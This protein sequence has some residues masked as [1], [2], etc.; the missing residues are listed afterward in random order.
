MCCVTVR[1][2]EQNTNFT[3]LLIDYKYTE[4]I[5]SCVDGQ[6]TFLELMLACVLLH[7]T[8]HKHVLRAKNNLPKPVG[9]NRFHVKDP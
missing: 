6:H 2:T 9:L 7:C 3:Q 4:L 5:V 8:V 1:N